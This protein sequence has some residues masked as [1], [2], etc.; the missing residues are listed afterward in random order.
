MGT[1]S[2]ISTLLA[3]LA[4]L[5]AVFVAVKALRAT[6]NAPVADHLL[7]AYGDMLAALEDLS[8]EARQLQKVD[9]AYLNSREALGAS[10]GRFSTAAARVD[11]I[12]PP[13]TK[14]PE[15]GEWVRSVANNLASDLRQADEFAELHEAIFADGAVDLRPAGVSDEEWEEAK[16]SGSYRSILLL[17]LEAPSKRPKDFVDLETW[18]RPRILGFGDGTEW[19]D[20]HSVYSP[21]ADYMTQHVRLLDDFVR[22][23][24]VPWARASVRE[25]LD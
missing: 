14:L 23:Y 7:I 19:E 13:V 8:A 4:S 17:G 25:A 3:G 20:H 6:R 15:Y 1:L 9:P 10:F 2:D 5:G 21:Y 11:L 22:E 24:L 18:F 16:R 12:E